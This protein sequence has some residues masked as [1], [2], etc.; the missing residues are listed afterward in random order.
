MQL[1]PPGMTT[2]EFTGQFKPTMNI[3]GGVNSVSYKDVADV[4]M[5][6]LEDDSNDFNRTMIGIAVK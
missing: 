2:E 3:S 6:A 4:L 1:S 5:Q